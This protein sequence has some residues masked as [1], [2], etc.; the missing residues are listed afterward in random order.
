YRHVLPALPYLLIL[1]SGLAAPQPRRE[2]SARPGFWM[3]LTYGSAAVLVILALWIHP[4]YLSYFNFAVGGPANGYRVLTDSNV[5]WGQDLL[6]LRA[7]MD[8]HDVE[9]IKL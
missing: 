3:S 8:E 6:R 4:H 5:D 1:A 2:Q 9:R 7:W